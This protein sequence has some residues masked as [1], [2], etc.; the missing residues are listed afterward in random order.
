MIQLNIQNVV[1]FYQLYSI[2]SDVFF[3]K[4]LFRYISLDI[5][6]PVGKAEPALEIMFSS[7][8]LLDKE[9]KT[10]IGT[11]I[12]VGPWLLITQDMVDQF[13]QL[14][15]DTAWI[16]TDPIR[17]QKESPYGTTIFV[18]TSI[19]LKLKFAAT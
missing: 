10:K 2:F 14:A 6:V 1:L 16:H 15:G 7:F 13:A 4:P 11:E 18:T 9:L 3:Q 17:A 5:S 8:D 12:H 19:R